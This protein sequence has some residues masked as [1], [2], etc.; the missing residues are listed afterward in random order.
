MKRFT[1]Q[2]LTGLI[3]LATLL[4]FSSSA[5]LHAQL[6]TNGGFESSSV[7][8]ISATGTKGWLVQFVNT[9]APPPVYEIVSDTVRQGS[10]AL[11]VTVHGLGTNQWDIQ[12]VAD[13]IPARPGATYNYSVWAKAA[14]AGAQVNFTVGNYSYTEYKAYTSCDADHAVAEVHDDVYRER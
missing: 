7:G 6:V 1:M 11:K 9:I 13:S 10:R 12:V 2:S 8:D 3:L 14:K 4:V 5:V